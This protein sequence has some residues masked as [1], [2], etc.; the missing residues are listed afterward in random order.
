MHTDRRTGVDRLTL[1]YI[2][3][4][5]VLAAF[6]RLLPYLLGPDRS[7]A[8]QLVP[9][10]AVALF[11][12]S[13]LRSP[14]AWLVPLA[15][16]FV[17]DLLISIPLAKLELSAFSLGTPIIYGS[18]ALY[19]LIGRLIRQGA[20]APL[21]VGVAALLGSVQF[22]LLSNLTVWLFQTL[23]PKTLAGLGEC[24]LAGLPFYRNTLAGD[25][26]YSALFFGVHAVLVWLSEGEAVARRD[27]VKS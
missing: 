8:W 18:F 22:F 17:S 13:R 3:V 20:L 9:V 1:V 6:A 19:V 7:F 10:G 25:L 15:V 2:L 21:M 5:G 11:A 26:L 23:Y 14:A 12:G 4:L 16:M 24:Y 27:E